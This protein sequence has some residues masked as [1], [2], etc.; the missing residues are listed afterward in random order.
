VNGATIRTSLPRPGG[1]ALACVRAWE[2]FYRWYHNLVP[3]GPLLLLGRECYRGRA[4]YFPDQT[5]I[6]PGDVIGS[7]HLDND[8]L[9][10]IA[11]TGSRHAIA[12][13]VSLMLRES[14]E[15]L[16]RL[17]QSER[18]NAPVVFHGVTWMRSHGL[19]AGFVTEQM[20]NGWRASLLRWQFGV[21]RMCFAPAIF[22]K[23]GVIQPREF[24]I[25][26]QQLQRNFSREPG[27]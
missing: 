21:L 6:F 26:R 15:D 27:L 11:G 9:A 14:L 12:W 2:R 4:R 18:D 23:A 25:T 16:S 13:Q 20:M 24:W 3:V 22:S 19:K 17:S 8:R 10:T 1:I 7:L 5:A